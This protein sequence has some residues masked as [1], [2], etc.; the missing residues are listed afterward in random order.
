MA[1]TA[2]PSLPDPLGCRSHTPLCPCP[3]VSSHLECPSLLFNVVHACRLRPS[4]VCHLNLSL[5]LD[6]YLPLYF[7]LSVIMLTVSV[8]V[9]PSHRGGQRS[10]LSA[11]RSQFRPRKSLMQDVA[12]REFGSG[13]AGGWS[14]GS[15]VSRH[16][17]PGGPPL[18]L[19]L[20][21]WSG[22]AAW[23]PVTPRSILRR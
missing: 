17:S 14:P 7:I 19:R 11:P 3:C 13:R 4:P 12:G 21:R 5:H 6:E 23:Y 18:P 15:R 16:P 8:S 22:G 10:C 2:W 1:C 9:S 20:T